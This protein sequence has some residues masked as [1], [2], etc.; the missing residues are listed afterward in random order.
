MKAASVAAPS[1]SESSSKVSN[2]TLRKHCDRGISAAAPRRTDRPAHA[3]ARLRRRFPRRGRLAAV[4]EGG[5]AAR[6]HEIVDQRVA[7]A[8]CRRRS[9][10]VAPPPP[11]Q[12]MLATPPMLSDHQRPR[13]VEARRQRA[14]EHRHQRRPLPA[15]RHVGG[16][17]VV[18]DRYAGKARQRVAGADLHGEPALGP[19]QHGLAVKADDIGPRC[20]ARRGSAATASPWAAVTSRSA[21]ASAPGRAARSSERAP[22][23]TAP[24]A[25]APARPPHR[26]GSRAARAPRCARRRSRSAATSTPSSEVP[27]ISPIACMRTASPLPRLNPMPDLINH[28]A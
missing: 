16:A 20:G 18:G 25:A 19:V 11:R 15:G 10:S 4:V 3:R 7:R 8:R 5:A 13:P 24:G 26:A 6:T 1:A 27:L 28:P 23:R 17:E 2:R 14:V 22:P 12:V 21:A 9:G